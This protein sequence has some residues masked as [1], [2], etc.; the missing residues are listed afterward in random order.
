[1]GMPKTLTIDGYLYKRA[2]LIADRISTHAMYDCHLFRTLKADTVDGLIDEWREECENPDER[3]GAPF[4]CPV[5]VSEGDR[6]IRRVGR[7]LMRYEP[8]PVERFR[9][10]LL[11]DPDVPRLLAE[12]GGAR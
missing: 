5:I 7:M 1:M 12:R 3:Y 2:D 6:E 11:G 8:E 10:A 9:E 4:L